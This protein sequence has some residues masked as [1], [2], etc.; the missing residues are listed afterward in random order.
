MKSAASIW[1]WLFVLHSIILLI[2]NGV[3]LTA[4]NA[5]H[6]FPIV[7]EVL[8]PVGSSNIPPTVLFTH[9]SP[10]LITVLGL[11]DILFVVNT[12]GLAIRALT[13]RPL[14]LLRFPLLRLK[15]LRL[16]ISD[17]YQILRQKAVDIQQAQ[18]CQEGAKRKIR[19]VETWTMK[20]HFPLLIDDLIADKTTVDD[21]Y[22]SCRNHILRWC[23]THD[24][25]I[26]RVQCETV[27]LNLVPHKT[28]AERLGLA[29]VPPRAASPQHVES[30]R[31][32]S[33]SPLPTTPVL[34]L[35]DDEEGIETLLS[36]VFT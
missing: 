8:P 12:S 27:E 3:P 2:L 4:P 32:R 23:A 10:V 29:T 28:V 20:K 25:V 11:F 33:W 30:P 34:T 24:I 7:S 16:A 18:A 6:T 36:G 35:S 21:R 19:T 22:S 14:P 1:D 17:D 9:A 13:P 26:S 31:V 5:L 15:I